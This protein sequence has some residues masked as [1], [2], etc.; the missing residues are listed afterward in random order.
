MVLEF[1]GAFFWKRPRCGTFE[2]SAWSLERRVILDEHA[3]A[4][5]G[6]IT[7]IDDLACLVDR[8][9]EN[10]VDC[11]ILARWMKR[12]RHRW[13]GAVDGSREAIRVR[14]IIVIIQHLHLTDTHQ[15]N[16]A[17][18]PSLAIA[19]DILRRRPFDVKLAVS[20]LFLG[21]H[22]TRFGHTF[23]RSFIHDPFRGE[24]GFAGFRVRLP[25]RQ[26]FRRT[27]EKHD[28]VRRWFAGLRRG[29]E[30]SRLNPFGLGPVAIV[31]R[32]RVVLIRRIAVEWGAG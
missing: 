16:A 4:E 1:K 7:G 25:F 8:T 17:I 6:E 18:A 32:P 23:H 9:S 19:Q 20:P 27:I 10:D 29:A 21:P 12:V 30:R 28:R 22:V 24:G 11:L 14:W 15:K 5:N 3:V 2:M 13:V 26:R 31:D